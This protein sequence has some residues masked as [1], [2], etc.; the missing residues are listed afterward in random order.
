MENRKLCFRTEN[1]GNTFN[2]E[3]NM[4]VVEMVYCGF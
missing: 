2:P 4:I 3:N 1:F